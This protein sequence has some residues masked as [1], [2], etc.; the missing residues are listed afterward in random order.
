MRQHGFH[1]AVSIASRLLG[2]LGLDFDFGVPLQN[3][4][5]SRI[6]ESLYVG[7]RPEP[8]DLDRLRHEGITHVVSCLEEHELRSVEFLSAELD[9]LGIPLRDGMDQDIAASFPA[10]FD[11][12]S[13][14]EG[15]MLVHCQAGVSRSATFATALLMKSE[16]QTFFEAFHDLRKARPGVLPNIGFASQLQKLEHSLVPNQA[17]EPSSLTRYLCEICRAPVEAPIL[18]EALERHDYDA[19][20]ALRAIF[21]GEIPRVVQGVRF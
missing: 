19:P 5:F 1:A 9:T 21:G 17:L 12:A 2:L 13:R 8:K 15:K 11:F 20:R 3:E 10:F 16:Q 18:Q 4:S 6:T 14:V 7:A